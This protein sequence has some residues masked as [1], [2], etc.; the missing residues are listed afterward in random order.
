MASVRWSSGA[1]D[2]LTAIGTYFER[3]SPPYA[4]SIVARLYSAPEMLAD[5]PL[6]GRAV[7]E[8]RVEHIREIGREGYR[9]VYTVSGDTV[10]VPAVLHGRQDIGRSLRRDS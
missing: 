2:D 5:H 7:P 4:R 8:I 6:S 3:A 1:V 9:I 10:D